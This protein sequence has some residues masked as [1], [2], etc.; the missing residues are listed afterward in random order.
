MMDNFTDGGDGQAFQKNMMTSFIQIAALVI[1]VSYCLII[2]SPFVGLAIWGVVMAVAIYPVFL[3]VSGMLGG[4]QKLAAA[5]FILIGLAVVLIPGWAMTESMILSIMSFSSEL[6]AGNVTVPPPS[7]SVAGWPLIGERLYA[8]WVA[9]AGNLEATLN[10]FQPQLRELGE[11]LARMIGSTALGVLQ[12]AAAV[13]IAGV[14]MMYAKSGYSLSCSVAEKIS[15]ERGRYLT[16]LS[17]ATIRSVT[18]GVIGVGVIQGVLAG[19]GFYVMGLPHAGLL[20]A[21]VLITSII[22]VPALLI[23]APIVVWVFSFAAPLPATIF[24]IYMLFASLS[25]NVLKP[26]LLG[27]GVDLP[28]M[29]VLFGALGGM[30]A[31]GI[32]GLFLGAVILGLGY[33]IISQ[34]LQATEAPTAAESDGDS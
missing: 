30:V 6:K 11:R 8:V 18:N 28:A 24:A 27:R 7:E 33:E 10:E 29:I 2:V 16:D 4:R 15:P 25:D 14:A 12:I 22:Q 9:A 31:Y 19:I 17:V 5:L 26:L 34:W 1:L 23:I 20:A 21:I 32:I 13:I 3:K